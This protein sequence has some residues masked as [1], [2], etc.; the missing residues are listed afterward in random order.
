MT[1]GGLGG[2]QDNSSGFNRR[3]QDKTYFNGLLRSKIAEINNELL[4][5]NKDINNINVDNANYQSYSRKYVIKLINLISS[6]SLSLSLYLL[7]FSS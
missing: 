6:L 7:A 5:M 4:R 3:I 1:R 2:L